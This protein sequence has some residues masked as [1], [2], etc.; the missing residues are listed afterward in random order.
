MNHIANKQLHNAALQACMSLPV[1]LISLDL[2][3]R[4]PFRLKPP[5][6]QAAVA[7]GVHIEARVDLLQPR[8]I[9]GMVNGAVCQLH[10]S[11]C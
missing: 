4:L 1:D 8:R 3:K 6:L 11:A 7:R 10:C 5:L 2:T 9:L